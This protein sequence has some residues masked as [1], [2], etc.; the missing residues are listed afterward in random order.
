M[1]LHDNHDSK[2]AGHFGIYKTLERVKHNYHWHRMEE[3]I[4]DYVRACDTCQRDKPSRH[5]R[6]GQL[7]PLEVPYRPWS[8]ISMDWIADLPESNGYTQIWVIVDRFTKM[9]H[10]IPLPTK[11]TAKDIAK[12]FLKEIW[13]HH[14]LPTDI[15]SDRDT[16]ITSHF[17]QVLMDLLGIKTKLSTAFH[18][19]TDGQTDRVNQTSEQYLRH[20]CSW[21]Q[22]D[23]DD[24][25]P[26]AEF[27]CNSAKS[28]TTG[29]SPF[30]ANYWMLPKQSWEPLNKTPYIN[31]ASKLLKTVWKGI[32]ERLRE[33]IL[34]AQVRTARWHNLKCG[35]QPQLKVADLVLV[36]K[37]NIGPR[38]PSKKLDHKIA[39]PFPITKAVG[40]RAL[41][42]QL[43]EGSQAH[44]TF[45]VQLLEPYR[46]SREEI[47]K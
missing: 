43:P 28:K 25:L 4:K 9:A 21:K 41:C 17:W 38:R 36:D 40:K 11:V 32:W 14:V 47:R 18:P 5:R 1:I 8:S 31:P 20:Y 34:K 46:I 35:K 42:V 44:P 33:N 45:H 37:R 22:D 26:M 15:V 13:K 6:Y 10:L 16:K 19:E 24:L 30:E 2:I 12:I 7:E 39:G 29:I 27:A 3:D 23:W